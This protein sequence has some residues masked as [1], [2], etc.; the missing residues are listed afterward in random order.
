[1]YKYLNRWDYKNVKDTHVYGQGL[2]KIMNNEKSY[3][4]GW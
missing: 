2:E 4:L 3:I 1:M